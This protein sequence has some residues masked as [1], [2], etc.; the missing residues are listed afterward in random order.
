MLR[1]TEQFKF[2]CVVKRNG[3]I[4]TRRLTY[5]REGQQCEQAL[6]FDKA[7][8]HDRVSTLC[9]LE[10]VKSGSCTTEGLHSW[11]T[12]KMDSILVYIRVALQ[13]GF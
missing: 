5:I 3:R 8:A 2:L 6:H 9:G 10:F 1:G 4:A 13:M 7:D 11:N 12:T